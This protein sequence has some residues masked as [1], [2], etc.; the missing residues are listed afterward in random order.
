[1]RRGMGFYRRPYVRRRVLFRPIMRPWGMGFR[2]RPLWMGGG[3]LVFM[4]FGCLFL[5]ALM[6]LR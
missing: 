6:I 2:R 5:A 1:M 4:L 3:M